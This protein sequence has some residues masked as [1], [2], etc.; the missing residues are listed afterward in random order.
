MPD[1]PTDWKLY[2]GQRV[3]HERIT[4][5]PPP[6]PWRPMRAAVTEERPLR[7][8]AQA[9]QQAAADDAGQ[10]PSEAW[11]RR[12][13]RFHA[14]P[15]IVEVVNAALYLR[16]PLLVTG[17]P[18]SGKSSL[19]DAV[20]WELGL[21][22][23]LR[24]PVTSQSTLRDALYQ[25]DA[26]GRLQDER[27]ALPGGPASPAAPDPADARRQL[28]E[29]IGRYIRLGPL[30]TALLP[31]GRPRALLVDEIDKSDVDLPNDLLNVF[32]EGVFDIPE[33]V[34][35][36]HDGPVRVF[37]ADD[38]QP[39]VALSRGRVQCA[40]FP[41]IVMTSNGERDFPAPFLRRCLQL[42]M[43]N[44]MG[45]AEEDDN[46][47]GKR[48]REVVALHFKPEELQRAGDVVQHFID[49][50][51]QGHQDLATDQLLNAVY[52]VIE[53]HAKPAE[54]RERVLKT[55]EQALVSLRA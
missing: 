13:R 4:E 32:E 23:P 25:Y 27:S 14:T 19:V 30:G 42:R 48:L 54:E 7:T 44:P 33:L 11:V 10:G 31:T 21:G 5:L 40:Q 3:P 51:A 53:A 22:R 9:Q 39:E 43:P 15:A 6:P 49:R 26:I 45:A 8:L 17:K 2:T 41:L 55:L 18:G 35:L 34:R 20:A 38:S 29:R 50:V 52:F 12:G 16:R 28:A 24:W 1:Q 36:G 37:T 46:P 47:D